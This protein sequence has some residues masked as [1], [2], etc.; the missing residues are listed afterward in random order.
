MA[1]RNQAL[2]VTRF[3]QFGNPDDLYREYEVDSDS[4]HGRVLCGFGYLGSVRVALR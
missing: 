1:H 2:A 3:G 4:I